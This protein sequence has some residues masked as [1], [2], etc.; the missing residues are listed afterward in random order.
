VGNRI[1]INPGDIYGRLTIIKEVEQ[2]KWGRRQ[3]E[4]IC[5]HD[6]NIR[7]Y[8][9]N[10]LRIGVT[11][12]CG[13]YKSEI[14]INKREDVIGKTYGR[15]TV[16]EDLGVN[17]YYKRKVSAQCSCDE[18]IKE[19]ALGS[20][21]KGDTNSCGC[22]K[23]EVQKERCTFKK[24]DFEE[25]HPFFCK[26]EEIMDDPNGYGIL[27]KCKKCDKWLPP[28]NS[29]LYDRI[30]S[31]EKPIGLVQ[32]YF[33]CSGECKHNCSLYNLKSDPFE[34]K[35]NSNQPTQ[36]E[37]YIWSDKCFQNQRDEIGTNRCEI[38]DKEKIPENPLA[39]HH[40]EPKKLMPGYALDPVNGII[41]CRECP[42]E[43]GHKDECSTGRLAKLKCKDNPN[44]P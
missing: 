22:Y 14:Q 20:L 9:L 26:V 29:Q 8:L 15:L 13:C 12:S 2:N 32:N 1:E 21:K 19:Y 7:T 38:C 25:K 5:S 35:D 27:V 36:Y 6:G 31:I 39:A 44:E 37:L 30:S 43:Y 28:T 24:K 42:F 41:L 17:S 4:A 33:Y 34:K 18:N 11:T 3:V 16:I 23:S 10:S 40:I